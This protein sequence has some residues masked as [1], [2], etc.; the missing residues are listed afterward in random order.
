MALT[1]D[2]AALV[3]F[4]CEAVLYGSFSASTANKLIAHFSVGCYT[5]LFALSIYLK[6]KSSHRWNAVNNPIFVLGVLLF[7]ACTTHFAL[8]F[9]HFYYA[10]VCAMQYFSYA[11]SRHSCYRIPRASRDSETRKMASSEPFS[12]SQSRISWVNL[13]SSTA[14]GCCGPGVM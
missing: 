8:E 12:S 6:L 11:F 13:S 3:G 9:H 10:L 4:V 1:R 5:I 2:M 7:L 14:A